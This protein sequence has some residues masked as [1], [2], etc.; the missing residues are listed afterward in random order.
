MDGIEAQSIGTYHGMH[1]EA[2]RVNP[3]T[4]DVDLLI[5]GMPLIPV[6]ENPAQITCELDRALLGTLTH[7]R[8]GGIFKGDFGET[9]I[10]SSLPAPV[11]AR[12]ILI[13]GM[14]LAAEITPDI[15]GNLA[16][17]AAR[18][19][20]P[21]DSGTIACLLALPDGDA[22]PASIAQTAQHM[23]AH[24]LDAADS[25]QDPARFADKRWIFDL[26]TPHD[27]YVR[28]HFQSVIDQRSGTE[29]S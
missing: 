25:C 7:L 11:R 14:G 18:T 6:T 12:S 29:R 22:P 2:G 28:S 9:L 1:F 8:A 10:L 26:R 21:L 13:I 20:I 19:A 15:M 27:R 4:A 5:V 24:M 3:V 23:M 16:G 17:I